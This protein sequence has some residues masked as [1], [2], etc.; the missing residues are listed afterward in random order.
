M[1][2]DKTESDHPVNRTDDEQARKKILTDFIEKHLPALVLV[3]AEVVS[4]SESEVVISAPLEKNYNDK[5]TAFGG[6]QYLLCIAASWGLAYLNAMSEGLEQPD[7]IGAEGNI[8]YLKP[9]RSTRILTRARA[10]QEDMQNF[11]NAI[12]QKQRA[13]LVQHSTVEDADTGKAT[14]F[15]IKYVLFP[16]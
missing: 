6:S 7:L 5:G 15:Q 2:L 9:V 12:R 11:R 10:N 14:E 13:K 8:K 1:P 4:A 3:G 16:E